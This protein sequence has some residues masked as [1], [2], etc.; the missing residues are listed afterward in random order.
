MPEMDGKIEGMALNVPVPNG[1]ML[2]LSSVLKNR[3]S[4]EDIVKAMENAAAKYPQLIEV[5]Y[6][7][8]VSTDVINNSHSM[9]YDVQATML[10][11]GRMVK[12]LSWYHSAFAMA[13][14]IKELI[15]AYSNAD[16]KGGKR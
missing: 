11:P 6:D 16:K 12:T 2:D 5:M 14:R 7:P 3:A 1:S 13:A 4:K 15:I 10:T 8:I 9:V